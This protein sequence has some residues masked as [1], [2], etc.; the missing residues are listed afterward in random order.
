MGVALPVA[1]TLLEYMDA[2]M[3]ESPVPLPNSRIVFPQNGDGVKVI[4]EWIMKSARTKAPLHTCRPTRLSV[5]EFSY[6]VVNQ[7]QAVYLFIDLTKNII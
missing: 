7:N 6:S 4:D 2:T 5:V 3:L 1:M